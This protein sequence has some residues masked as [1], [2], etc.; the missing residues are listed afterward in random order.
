[1]DPGLRELVRRRARYSCEYCGI[2][3][4][5]TAWATFHIEHITPRKHG[6]SDDPSNLA[7][8]CNRCNQSKGTNLTGLDPKTG[9]LARLFNP[10]RHQ[11]TSHFRWEGPVLVG[12]TPIGRATVKVLS[13]NHGQRIAVRKI[14]IIQGLFPPADYTPR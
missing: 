6:G 2:P 9:K 7:L 12:R 1:M 3:E 13:I 5:L 8:A 14:L 4:S 11:W 10:R